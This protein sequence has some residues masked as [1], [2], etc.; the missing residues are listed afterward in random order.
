MA[1]TQEQMP[2]NR[3]VS[4]GLFISL[5]FLVRPTTAVIVGFLGDTIGLE[6]AF[7]WGANFSFLALPSI[8]FLPQLAQEK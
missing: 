2:H 6:S 4:N 8:F 3:A 1:I 7:F 5:A